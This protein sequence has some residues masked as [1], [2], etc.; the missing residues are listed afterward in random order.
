MLRN[1]ETVFLAVLLCIAG[2]AACDE[3]GDAAGVC[4]D[5]AYRCNS[6]TVERCAGGAWAH[7]YDCEAGTVCVEGYCPPDESGGGGGGDDPIDPCAPDPDDFEEWAWEDISGSNDLQTGA[8]TV[9]WYE[10]T[11]GASPAPMEATLHTAGDVDWYRWSIAASQAGCGAAPTF[12][13]SDAD[14]DFRLAFYARCWWGLP[15]WKA[16]AG[17]PA[18]QACAVMGQDVVRCTGTG[19]IDLSDLR[20]PGSDTG[21]GVSQFGMEAYVQVQWSV[22]PAAGVCPGAEYTLSFDF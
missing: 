10:D 4:D 15:T 12:S 1:V 11:C 2:A 18:D 19:G 21:D 5:G 22:P 14:T 7:L 6:T 20:C 9:Y 16:G 3:T 13:V 17:A 8:Y